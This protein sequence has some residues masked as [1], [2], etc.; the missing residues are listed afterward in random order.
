MK[1]KAFEFI[2]VLIILIV[3]TNNALRKHLNELKG[4]YAYKTDQNVL[5]NLQADGYESYI[6]L[7]FNEDCRYPN[8][9]TNPRRSDI[10]YIINRENNDKITSETEL[11]INKDFRIEIYFSSSVRDM[12]SF[13]DRDYDDN[14]QY[15]ISIDF[16]NFDSSLLSDIRW[17]FFGC[18]SLET[19]ILTNFDTSLV[20][21]MSAIFYGCS[22]LKSIDLS[23][24]VTSLVTNMG[25]MFYGC[26]S[27]KSI[28]LSHFDTS[29]VLYMAYMFYRCSSL[30]SIDL[31]NFDTSK[32][33][34][35]WDMFNG[36]RSLKY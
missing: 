9:F 16:T 12:R 8:G 19:I 15:L 26:S 31:S 1:L 24:F 3:S 34:I 27:L 4:S 25:S 14:I 33:D 13:F 29:K 30:K 5:R 21:D 11:I 7:Y 23:N 18:N 22:S 32:V 28:D 36:C 10:S 17:M 6:I 2:F 20:T 35:M